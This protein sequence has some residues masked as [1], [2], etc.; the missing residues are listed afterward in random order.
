MKEW[1]Y[2]PKEGQK[3]IQPI[4]LIEAQDLDFLEGC[5]VKYICRYK[6]KGGRQDLLKAQW[7]LQRLLM[8]WED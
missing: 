6:R 8:R 4:D 3:K 7:Y 1:H 5:I 2:S